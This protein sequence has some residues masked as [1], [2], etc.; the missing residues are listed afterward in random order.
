MSKPTKPK[1]QRVPRVIKAKNTARIIPVSKLASIPK[2]RSQ[3][4]TFLL[5]KKFGVGSKH[6]I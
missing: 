5:H 4:K 1:L 3:G 2:R 6:R